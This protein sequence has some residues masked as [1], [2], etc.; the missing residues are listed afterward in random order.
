MNGGTEICNYWG[1]GSL[2][3]PPKCLCKAGFKGVWCD[4]IAPLTES[5]TNLQMNESSP[6]LVLLGTKNTITS[7]SSSEMNTDT[8]VDPKERKIIRVR[9]KLE[10]PLQWSGSRDRYIGSGRR[11]T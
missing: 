5:S 9:N 1:N 10:N 6:T 4:E 7:N 2:V 8:T 3:E 11:T